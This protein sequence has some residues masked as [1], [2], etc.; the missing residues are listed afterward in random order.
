MQRA[1][2]TPLKE[3]NPQLVAIKAEKQALSNAI[4]LVFTEKRTITYFFYLKE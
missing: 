2:P 4:L 1:S 3:T